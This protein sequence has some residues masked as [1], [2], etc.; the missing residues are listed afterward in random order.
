MMQA[1]QQQQM[2]QQQQQLEM[3]RYQFEQFLAKSKNDRDWND[4]EISKAKAEVDARDTVA[5]NIREDEKLSWEI[6][7]GSAEISLEDSQKR[8]VNID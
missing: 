2:M 3:D 4:L 7:K 6:A 1:Q 8:A 5:D